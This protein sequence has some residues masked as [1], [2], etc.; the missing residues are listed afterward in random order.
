MNDIE[1]QISK[2]ISVNIGDSI[3]N[4]EFILDSISIEIT[5]HQDSILQFVGS[6]Q[7]HGTC[8]ERFRGNSATSIEE[9]VGRKCE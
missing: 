8:E 3:D 4:Y 9:L 5:N 1:N 7:W 6:K 2:T